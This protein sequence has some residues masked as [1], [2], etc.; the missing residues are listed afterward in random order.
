MVFQN[1]CKITLYV[2]FGGPAVAVRPGDY[3]EPPADLLKLDLS[4]EPPEFSP[5]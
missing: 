2:S 3:Y 5:L 4:D 1:N